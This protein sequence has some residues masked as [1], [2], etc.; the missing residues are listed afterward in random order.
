[1][2]MS[3]PLH[4]LI[5]PFLPLLPLLPPLLLLLLLPVLL[6]LM[7]GYIRRYRTSNRTAQE[8]FASLMGQI[9]TRCTADQG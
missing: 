1:M 4:S 9:S 5:S 2:C 6:H 3:T 8:R 7:L